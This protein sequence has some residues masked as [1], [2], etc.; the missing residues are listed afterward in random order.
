MVLLPI[1]ACTSHHTTVCACATSSRARR[2][3]LAVLVRNERAEFAARADDADLEDALDENAKELVEKV[4]ARRAA[5]TPVSTR[6][7]RTRTHTR[8]ATHKEK[9]KKKPKNLCIGQKAARSA[10]G[11]VAASLGALLDSNGTAFHRILG[12][13]VRRAELL[14]RDSL[15]SQHEESELVERV[16][17]RRVSNRQHTTIAQNRAFRNIVHVQERIETWFQVIGVVEV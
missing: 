2:S 3:H 1:V 17:Q 12:N 11:N 14:H 9:R 10:P 4:N 6:C 15:R 7:A 13:R 16:Q 5:R 8:T